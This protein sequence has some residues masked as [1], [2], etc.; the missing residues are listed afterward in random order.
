M[1]PVRGP[2]DKAPAA[3]PGAALLLQRRWPLPAAGLLIA[4]NRIGERLCRARQ[5]KALPPNVRYSLP[6]GRR[7]AFHVAP[8]LSRLLRTPSRSR[9]SPPGALQCQCL[10][11]VTPLAAGRLHGGGAPL[12]AW[13]D[14]LQLSRS[15][16]DAWPRPCPLAPPSPQCRHQMYCRALHSRTLRGRLLCALVC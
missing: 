6:A 5:D 14:A 8:A 1:G 4:S 12:P 3:C 16:K 2:R 9:G 13:W 7:V 10:P 11:P 15:N